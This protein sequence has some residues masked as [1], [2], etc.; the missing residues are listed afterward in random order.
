MPHTSTVLALLALLTACS[1]QGECPEAVT[2]VASD[3]EVG[4]ISAVGLD[5][6]VERADQAIPFRW[7][8]GAETTLNGVLTIGVE[9]GQ[10]VNSPLCREECV[11][12]PT[13]AG[14]CGSDWLVTH[15]A[16]VLWTDDGRLGGEAVVGRALSVDGQWRLDFVPARGAEI[17]GDL[18][19]QDLVDLPS[20]TVEWQLGATLIGGGPTLFAAEVRVESRQAEGGESRTQ[21]QRLGVTPGTTGG[22]S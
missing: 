16:G 7:E 11:D 17:Q 8:D 19:P 6:W 21:K 14:V 18:V 5:G 9:T 1:G 2:Q 12:E 20:N 15:A 13:P 3:V 4:G 10:A 22:G